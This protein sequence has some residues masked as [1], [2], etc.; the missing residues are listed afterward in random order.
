MPNKIQIYLNSKYANH[1][2][3][4]TANS[5]LIFYFTSPIVKPKDTLM[6]IKVLNASFPVSF[7]NV[8]S[9][10]N[11]LVV[12]NT[13]YVLN[14]GNYNCLTLKS[15][16]ADKLGVNFNVGYDSIRNKFSFTATTNFT[17]KK[18]SSCLHILGF[19]DD[20]DITS[21]DSVLESTYGA[22]LSGD[23]T[24]YISIN[25]VTCS[26]ISS[27]NQTL[28]P[29]VK[30][31]VM[32]VPYGGVLFVE[33]QSDSVATVR[34]EF[35]NFVHVRILGEDMVSC[36]D[37]QNN[38]WQIT[39]EVGFVSKDNGSIGRELGLEYK[40]VYDAYLQ[41]LGGAQ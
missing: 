30:S 16:L 37:F 21:T 23:N 35:V 36:L 7:T 19:A 32:N 17:F 31:V 8:N 15:A 5:D 4:G 13:T 14:T 39:L 22:D 10:N 38:N 12:D 34:E 27:H 11:K 3:N 33:D 40:K 28:T 29:V 1:K 18:E 25:N 6:T 9:T 26:N 24:I 41:S 20:A 2:N